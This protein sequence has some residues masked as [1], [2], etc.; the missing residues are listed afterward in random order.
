MSTKRTGFN[1]SEEEQKYH[2]NITGY[3]IREVRA[4]QEDDT[5]TVDM[6]LIPK[7]EYI[8]VDIKIEWT[9]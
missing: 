7:V 1:S 3:E 5:I 2:N 9:H 8:T 6:L 4:R